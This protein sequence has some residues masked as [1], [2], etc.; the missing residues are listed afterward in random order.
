[1]KSK[2]YLDG[3]QAAINEAISLLDESRKLHNEKTS[4]ITQFVKSDF[5]QP[6][7]FDM[8]KAMMEMLQEEFALGEIQKIMYQ[9]KHKLYMLKY[10]DKE[11]D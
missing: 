2:D 7:E 9:L 3:Y 5:T 6:S 11:D 4:S 10:E 8:D 1:M